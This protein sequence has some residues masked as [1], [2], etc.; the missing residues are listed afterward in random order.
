[1]QHN[2]RTRGMYVQSRTC[3]AWQHTGLAGTGA[4]SRC[5][6]TLCHW[7]HYRWHSF[8]QSLQA[9][10]LYLTEARQVQMDLQAQAQ[11]CL[12]NTVHA[13][14]GWDRGSQQVYV[15]VCS[16]P[17]LSCDRIFMCVVCAPV[18][19]P[20]RH[21]GDEQDAGGDAEQ[22]N[23]ELHGC[24]ASGISVISWSPGSSARSLN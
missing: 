11:G 22:H 18:A 19:S 3:F 20:R 6:K 14:A 12:G 10:L 5:T 23:A 7:C 1:M 17:L 2:A 16:R 13:E 4:V 9:A 15:T 21:S 8:C 24:K